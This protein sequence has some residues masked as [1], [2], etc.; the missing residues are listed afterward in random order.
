MKN[1]LLI[2]LFAFSYSLSGT[3]YFPLVDSNAE[4]QVLHTSYPYQ[5]QMAKSITHQV[6]ALYGD[7]VIENVTYKKI[8]L[9]TEGN[10]QPPFLYFGALREEDK[11]IY[12]RGN[13]YFTSSA[14]MPTSQARI[15]RASD[16]MSAENWFGEE[17]VLYDFNAKKGEYLNWG[18]EYH[19]VIAEDSVLV[20]TAYRRRL[21][22]SNEDEIVE[23]IGSI[24]RGLL[25]MASPIP[26]CSDYY[27]NWDFEN[28]SHMGVTLFR[29]AKSNSSTGYQ[30][31]YSHRKAYFETDVHTTTTLKMDS[32]A[33]LNDSVFYPART[34]Q[35]IGD[36]CYDPRGSGWAGKKIVF[37]KAWN[38]FFNADNDTL[39]IKTDAVLNESWTLYQQNNTTIT[40]TVT[41][42][43]TA[44]VLGVIDSVKT[45][46]LHVFDPT[47]K[48]MP[49]ELENA[50]FSISKQ[51]GY[52]KAL[53]FTYFP[54]VKYSSLTPEA[55][56]FSLIG[57]T[58]PVL[59]VDEW[60]TPLVISHTHRVSENS[61]IQVYPTFATETITIELKEP[62][63]CTFQLLN[64]QGKI[65]LHKELV[66]PSNEIKIE[67]LHE[68][69][70]FYRI[71]QDEKPLKSG[72]ITKQ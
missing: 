71:M 33:F 22:L 48:P 9:K 26:T 69:I 54:S 52:T 59:G 5:F 63:S 67:S 45:F 36:E 21:R 61:G 14:Y 46:T 24:V 6:Y 40:A 51:Y 18:Y 8:G 41:R 57:L 60:G 13:G 66:Q 12:Y 29:A 53:N 56:V 20:G 37:D 43:D 19:Q 1:Y 38:Y 34:A 39:K 7:T 10:G 28:Y 3:Q 62:G 35:L 11:K 49:H 50:I 55:K 70:Y 42:W 32:C 47:M 58:N 27:D 64:A 15:N 72:K 17:Q 30:T 25:S 2:L 23:G 44:S 68:G 4:W 31:V 65:V 16:C